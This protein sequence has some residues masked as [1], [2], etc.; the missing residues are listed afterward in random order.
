MRGRVGQA[1]LQAS[2]RSIGGISRSWPRPEAT[3]RSF[4]CFRN[5]PASS[6]LLRLPSNGPATK[7]DF[8]RNLDRYGRYPKLLI[9]IQN[10]KKLCSIKSLRRRLLWWRLPDLS[11]S[12]GLLPISFHA[13]PMLQS[14][15]SSSSARFA[16][17]ATWTFRASPSLSPIRSTRFR[18]GLCEWRQAG[19]KATLDPG[20]GLPT[21][22]LGPAGSCVWPVGSDCQ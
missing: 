12:R 22:Q 20:L 1:F 5:N 11:L 9:F 10:W 17:K 18:P 16:V 21:Q 6:L 3:R 7:G 13:A 2:R 15:C 8:F 19:L 4:A 14:R